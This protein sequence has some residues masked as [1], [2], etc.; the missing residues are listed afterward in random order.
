MANYVFDLDTDCEVGP[1]GKC[2]SGDV[3]SRNRV[4]G[5]NVLITEV[6]MSVSRG[7]MYTFDDILFG[8][9]QNA[10]DAL[11]HG[12]HGCPRLTPPGAVSLRCVL[13]LVRVH[14]RRR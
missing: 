9:H 14:E 6:V 3:R 7:P 2:T 13:R 8:A 12:C 1:V 4:E 5:A 11:V 10:V